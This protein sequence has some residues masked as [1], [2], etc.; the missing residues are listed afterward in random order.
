[1]SRMWRPATG[2][3]TPRI[4]SL[5][6]REDG[7]QIAGFKNSTFL[8]NFYQGFTEF[9][10]HAKYSSITLSCSRFGTSIV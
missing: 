2:G 8:L 1:M 10:F 5:S 3:A 6:F 9:R 7:Y 4:V